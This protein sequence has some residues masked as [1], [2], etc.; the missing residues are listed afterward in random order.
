MLTCMGET[1][2]ARV[3]ASL[4]K[5][6]G[7]PE[8]ITTTLAEYEEMAVALAS[9]PERLAEIKQ[10]LARNRANAPLFN[11]EL[12]ARNLEAAYTQMIDTLYV[13]LPARH[14]KVSDKPITNF[15]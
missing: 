9:D 7:M 13:A 8:L 12:F 15:G 6:V 10:K 11:A 14:I 2:A 3:A 5:A 4:L 1:F